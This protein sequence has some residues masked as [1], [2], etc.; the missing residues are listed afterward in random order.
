VW[1]GGGGGV[2]LCWRPYSAGV[3]LSLTDLSQN[4]QNCFSTPNKNLGGEG[5]SDR[6]T[7]AAKSLYR[8]MLLDND[9]WNF[10]SVYLCTIPSQ[11][12]IDLKRENI[13]NK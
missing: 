9:I 12:E 1:L 5:D 8:S 4:L 11:Y 6:K 7:T 3:Y 13:Q 2:E 10:F